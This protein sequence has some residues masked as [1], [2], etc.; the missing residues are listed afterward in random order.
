MLHSINW[1]NHPQ[2]RAL[3]GAAFSARMCFK[4]V[5]GFRMRDSMG[6]NVLSSSGNPTSLHHAVVYQKASSNGWL[7]TTEPYLNSIDR[8][9]V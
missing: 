4:Y 9:G 8:P 5:P 7:L 3:L 6:H 2:P 1:T